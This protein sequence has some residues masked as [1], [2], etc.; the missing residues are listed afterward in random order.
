MEKATKEEIVPNFQFSINVYNDSCKIKQINICV[1]SLMS[2]KFREIAIM[3]FYTES[4]DILCLRFIINS[5][6]S[7]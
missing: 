7:L 2:Y 5:F 1:I 3:G 4:A 6:R